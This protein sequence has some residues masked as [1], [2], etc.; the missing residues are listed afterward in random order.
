MANKTQEYLTRI[1]KAVQAI[2]ALEDGQDDALFEKWFL[3]LEA[4]VP[5]YGLSLRQLNIILDIIISPTSTAKR[6]WKTRL[7]KQLNCR[8]MLD[9]DTVLKIISTFKVESNYLHRGETKL[10]PQT[11]QTRLAS[12]LL[13]NFTN[14]ELDPRLLKLLNLVF[15]LL[16]IGYLRPKLGLF[17]VFLLQLSAEIDSKFNPRVFFTQKKHKLVLELYSSDQKNMLP[18]VLCFALFLNSVSR[19]ALFDS[20]LMAYT[21]VIDTA[22]IRRDVFDKIDDEFGKSLVKMKQLSYVPDL[23]LYAKNSELFDAIIRSLNDF[24]HSISKPNNKKRPY[25]GELT[26]ADSFQ[27]S[28]IYSA[29]RLVDHFKSASPRSIELL[30][31]MNSICSNL[32]L[33]SHPLKMESRTI[34]HPH[35]LHVFFK[36]LACII[37][38]EVSTAESLVSALIKSENNASGISEDCEWMVEGLCHLIKFSPGSQI[39][40]TMAIKLSE[41]G[42]ISGRRG[43]RIVQHELFPTIQYLRPSFETYRDLLEKFVVD[44][45]ERNSTGCMQ[46]LVLLAWNW[47]PYFKQYSSLLRLI[48]KEFTL[49]NEPLLNELI[50]LCF[51]MQNIPINIIDPGILV[52]KPMIITAVLLTGN[53]ANIDML[54]GHLLYCQKYFDKYGT[55]VQQNEVIRNL[56]QVHD[57]SMRDVL[58]YMGS[59]GINRG[60]LFTLPEYFTSKLGGSGTA[61]LHNFPGVKYLAL[62]SDGN[63][64]LIRLR[65]KGF[66]ATYSFLQERN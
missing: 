58:Q 42:G 41:I 24:T 37:D 59:T 35:D 18:V 4:I 60:S 49:N 45:Y 38:L 9:F 27:I 2:S 47:T 8:E 56:K 48:F 39:T 33:K 66:T 22:K 34:K 57:R 10:V 29:R 44:T 20:T 65:G 52:L 31:V 62:D 23:D 3:Q 36:I 63:D 16:P 46:Q 28:I 19:N 15:N 1:E 6:T 26:E 32:S 5:K 43:D 14:M 30:L 13:K 54:L 17:L 51:S 61:E 55:S 7:S 40:E 12:F 64:A 50:T 53:I 25:G 11:T 21:M